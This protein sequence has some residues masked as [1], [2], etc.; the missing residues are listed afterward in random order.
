MLSNPHGKIT[1]YSLRQ[2]INSHSYLARLHLGNLEFKFSSQKP[3]ECLVFLL[4]N[5]TSK[6][7]VQEF[8]H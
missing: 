4:V 2:K 7:E 8:I 5:L 6:V 3:T 1:K